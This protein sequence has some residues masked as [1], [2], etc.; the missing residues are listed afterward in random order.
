MTAVT[1][2]GDSIK[3]S[4]SAALSS[5]ITADWLIQAGQ[6]GGPQAIPFSTEV[7]ARLEALDEV[8]SVLQFRVAFPAAWATSESGELSAADFQEF[9][10]IV[11]QLINDDANLTPEELFELRQQLGTDIDIN[12][13]AAVDF[14]TLEEHIDP[15]FIEIDRSLVGPN[16][17][18]FEQGAAEDAGLEVGDT[19]S[20]LFICLL[21][22]SPS[23]RDRG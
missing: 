1:V 2:I 23:P 20:A 7:A 15:D 10:P 13:A 22:T 12:D 6:G 21:Y 3:T 18:Y 19:F 4:V 16:A 9:L 11:L 8:E 17:V 5:S 14:A